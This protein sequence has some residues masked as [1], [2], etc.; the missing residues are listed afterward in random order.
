MPQLIATPPS[1]RGD[2]CH[3][4]F[5]PAYSCSPFWPSLALPSARA[6][7]SPATSCST[8]L[9]TIAT[10]AMSTRP[11]PGM[12]VLGAASNSG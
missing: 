5:S 1:A 3:I 12:G 11:P 9:T 2:I 6:W 10:M 7:A 4:L 8:G